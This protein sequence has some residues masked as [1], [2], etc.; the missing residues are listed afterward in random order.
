MMDEREPEPAAQNK[1][2]R[3][4]MRA[5][6]QRLNTAAKVKEQDAAGASW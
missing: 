5:S 6:H 1:V 4:P 3:W 2:L